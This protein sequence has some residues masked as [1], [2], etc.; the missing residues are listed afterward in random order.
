MGI[1]LQVPEEENAP[2][3]VV[4]VFETEDGEVAQVIVLY[5]Q[6]TKKST[7][8]DIQKM[9]REQIIPEPEPII[10]VHLSDQ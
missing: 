5:E 1:K 10:A 4:A 7:I 8:M 6:D 9:P 3:K 2:E